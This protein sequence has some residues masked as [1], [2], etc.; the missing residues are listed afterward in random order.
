MAPPARRAAK[1]SAG[2]AAAAA[3]EQALA[4]LGLVRDIDLALHLPL[5]YEDETR[6]VP[7]D[8]LHDGETVQVDG[9]VADSRIQFRPRR[10]EAFDGGQHLNE[11]RPVRRDQP[12]ADKGAPVLVLQSG[13]GH[14]N[15]E[16]ALELGHHRAHHGALLLQAV[17]I[18]EED[19]DLVVDTGDLVNFGTVAEGTATEMFAGIAS[20]PVPYLFTRGNHDA[21]SA[22]DTAI[23]DRMA[24]IPNVVLLQRDAVAA[25]GGEV[26]FGQVHHHR[27]A[28][29]I[30][31]AFSLASSMVPTM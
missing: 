5:R 18:A 16:A 2:G 12:D 1:K 20:L 7:I 4:K 29:A 19:I 9:V 26:A 28:A 8:S 10:H 25:Q 30:F 17:D 11:M 13:L 14:G 24:S 31:L 3:P 21:S 15:V 27:A 23:L 22:T 6:V